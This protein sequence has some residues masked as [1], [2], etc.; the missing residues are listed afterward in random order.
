VAALRQLV[1]NRFEV[2]EITVVQRG[3][4]DSQRRPVRCVNIRN[5]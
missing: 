4:Q 3:E 1:D 2:A 5:W